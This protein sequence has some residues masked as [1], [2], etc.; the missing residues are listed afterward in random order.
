MI[1]KFIINREY[2]NNKIPKKI[3]YYSNLKKINLY[4]KIKN[5]NLEK[6]LSH[7]KIFSS[8]W[9]DENCLL[10][11]TKDSKLVSYN[12]K[13]DKIN[14]LYN[15]N[16]NENNNNI[17]GIH[18]ILQEYNKIFI[19]NNNKTFILN[20][21]FKIIK[22]YNYHDN[23]IYGLDYYKNKLVTGSKDKKIGILDIYTNHLIIYNIFKKIRY[24]KVIHDKIFVLT[25]DKKFLILDINTLRIIKQYSLQGDKITCFKYIENLDTFVIP[26]NNNLN[27]LDIRT[28]S[29]NKIFFLEQNYEIRSF[30]NFNNIFS[31]GNTQ[32]E[33]LFFDIRKNNSKYNLFPL[34]YFHKINMN[35]LNNYYNDTIFTHSYSKINKHLFCGGGSLHLQI[36]NNF[37]NIYL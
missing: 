4:Q 31:I 23:L 3:L 6:K 24:L 5:K 22:E 7:D 17:G 15:F 18:N 27:F 35:T 1:N 33:L 9:I 16:L 11:G 32:N 37:K 34:N 20:S 14:Q 10:Y 2:K 8:K 19:T 25:I 21:E 13:N 29:I 12:L 36:F 30:N 28:N 26:N